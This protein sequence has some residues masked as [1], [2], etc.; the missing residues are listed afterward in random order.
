[1][2]RHKP[3]RLPDFPWTACRQNGRFRNIDA[4]WVPHWRDALRWKLASFRPSRQGSDG[5][6]SSILPVVRVD[7][8]ALRKLPPE[9][10]AATWLG[11]STFLLQAGGLTLLTD[12]LF[13]DRCAPWPAPGCR[14]RRPSP[15]RFEESP[16]PDLV[17]LSH[18]HFDHCDRASLRRLPRTTLV[19]C[20]LGVGPLLERWGFRRVVEFGW[21]EFLAGDSWRLLCLPAQH[22]SARTLFDR[23]RALWC[24]WLLSSRGRQIFFAGDTGYARFHSDL[25]RLLAPV[26]LALLPIGAYRPSW[27]QQ[28][29]HLNPMEAVRLHLDL[30]ARASLAMHWGTFRLSD[31]PWDEPPLLLAEAK[32]LLGVSEDAFR[33]PGLGETAIL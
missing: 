6:E 2:V 28:P 23:D 24:S 12:P 9:R 27:F 13:G 21:G 8:A 4:P 20:P 18:A 22:A 16:L 30:G 29:L 33:T 26:D 7:W 11:H 1:M 19:C 17:I 10:I 32:R 3:E 5:S 31:E 15:F 14:R 25:G